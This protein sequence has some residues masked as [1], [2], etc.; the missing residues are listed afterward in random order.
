[1]RPLPVLILV[2][3]LAN[4]TTHADDGAASIAI[5]GIVMTREP[6][7]TMAKEV[8]SIS[9]SK[10]LVDYDF[11]NDSDSNITT[12][13][14]FPIPS[15]SF[16]YSAAPPQLAGF[17]DFKLWIDGKTVEFTTQVRAVIGKRDVTDLLKGS[18]IDAASFGHYRDSKSGPVFPDIERLGKLDRTHL[19]ALNAIDKLGGVPRWNVEKKY[20]WQQT[21]PAHSVVHVS[22]EYTPVLGSTNSVSYGLLQAKEDPDSTKELA[23]LCIDSGLR[24]K[25]LDYL[26]D[27]NTIIPFSYIDF[28][29]TTAN[30]W[31]TP[32]ED[33][34]LIV[35]RPHEPQAKVVSSQQ[36]FV[37]FCWDGPVT[38]VDADHFT[39]HVNNLVPTKELRI[40]FIEVEHLKPN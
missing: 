3:S 5:G 24:S 22:H 30:T 38:R 14:A 27:Q 36:T 37:S 17:D 35:E 40:G 31:K 6:R 15:Y 26:K 25:L 19:I 2:A 20:Y 4:S 12:E 33:F 32:I 28:I 18:H 9:E 1:M 8:L 11:R 39:T 13:V 16:N 34:T 21:F 10:V 29:L 7:I 23:T